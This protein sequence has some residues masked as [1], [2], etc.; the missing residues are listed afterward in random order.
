MATLMQI[1]AALHVS[2]SELMSDVH[3]GDIHFI[4]AAKRQLIDDDEHHRKSLI[5]KKG[6]GTFEIFI[7]SISP[8]MST[9][10]E[11]YTHGNAQECV[12]VLA[13]TVDVQ[14]NSQVIRMSAGDAVEYRSDMPHLATNVGEGTAEVMFVVGPDDP[15]VDN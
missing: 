9:A 5:T 7:H 8:G 2:M 12:F 11:A 14:I 3:S 1:A 4:P 15:P 10:D 6:Y 13:G